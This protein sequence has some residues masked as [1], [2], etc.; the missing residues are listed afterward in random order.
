[1][2]KFLRDMLMSKYNRNR[3]E[4]NPYGSRGGYVDSARGRGRGRDMDEADY[5][6]RDYNDY[7]DMRRRDYAD[8]DYRG[9]R[10]YRR[11][12]RTSRGRDY[13]DYAEYDDREYAR[14]GHGEYGVL[15]E[16]D[17]HKWQKS[18]KNN[19][20]TKGE[21]FRKEQIT[22]LIKQMNIDVQS[23]GGEEIFCLAMNMMYSDYCKTAKEYG[24]DK[25]D[26][27]AKLA[28]DFLQD[29]DFGGEPEEK[30]WLYYKCIAEQDE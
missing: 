20:G 27:Y 2:N 1:M 3:D 8:E 17:M 21:H 10:E 5:A 4:R 18:L 22:P 28:K 30:L 14:D 11:G 9:N 7:G 15:S 24:V 6:R 16:E 23:M 12:G 29:K 19:D 13:G 25:P 26:F